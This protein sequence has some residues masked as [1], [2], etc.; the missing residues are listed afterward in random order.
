MKR[1]MIIVFLLVYSLTLAGCDPETTTLS[2]EKLI[3][4]TTKIELVEYTNEKPKFVDIDGANAP[5]F[6][7]D[8]ATFIGE[9]DE[10]YMEDVIQDIWKQELICWG[11]A[12]NE[13]IGKTLILYQEDGNMLVLFGYVYKSGWQATRYYGECIMFDENGAF[14]K[15]FGDISHEYV[16]LLAAEY[17]VSDP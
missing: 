2:R 11:R 6:D 4:H 14:I 12:L 10:N 9:L 3:S 5:V 13:P 17:F 8:K 1:F 7:F 15:Y 16:D